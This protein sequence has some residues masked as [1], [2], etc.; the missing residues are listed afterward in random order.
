[1]FLTLFGVIFSPTF[2]K[3]FFSKVSSSLDA[4]SQGVFEKVGA[5]HDRWVTKGTMSRRGTTSDEGVYW[6]PAASPL[7]PGSAQGTT[8]TGPLYS[9]SNSFLGERFY[10][11]LGLRG[12][13]KYT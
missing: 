11:R 1:M 3:G 10:A 7:G 2:L 12:N 13:G 6:P 4:L 9:F 5:R 8:P